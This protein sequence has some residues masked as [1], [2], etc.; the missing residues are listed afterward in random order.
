MVSRALRSVQGRVGLNWMSVG[1]DGGGGSSQLL[2]CFTRLCRALWLCSRAMVFRPQ[3]SRL[4]LLTGKGQSR[5]SPP[6]QSLEELGFPTAQ[7]PSFFISIILIQRLFQPPLKYLRYWPAVSS[8]VTQQMF[9]F[10]SFSPQKVVLTT[11]SGRHIFI[12]VRK[13]G[14][15]WCTGFTLRCQPPAITRD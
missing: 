13:G 1:S 11:S 5:F 6:Q 4:Q 12:P 2:T 3:A 8:E 9:S 14:C 7:M 10:S 15:G